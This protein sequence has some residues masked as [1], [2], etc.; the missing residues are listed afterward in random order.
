MFRFASPYYFFLLIPVGIAAWFVFRR[1]IRSGILFAPTLRIPE[2]RGS[3]RIIA[4]SLLPVL[5]IT[6]LVLTV[7][8]LARPQTV[9]SRIHNTSNA[10]GIEMVVDVSETMEALD[11]SIKTATGIKFRSRLEAAKETFGQFVNKRTDDLIGLV[12]FGGFAAT[13]VPLTA[14]HEALLHI[15]QG[16]EIPKPTFDGQGQVVDQEELL[17]AI[18]DALAT[19]CARLEHAKLKSKI[20]VLL[21]DGRSNTGIIKPEDATKIAKKMGI[22][23]YTIG[24]GSPNPAPFMRKDM[25]GNNTIVYGNVELD[26]ELLGNTAKITGGRYF[27]VRDP[28]GLDRAMEEINKL[29]KTKVERNIFEQYNELFP[30]FLWPALCLIAAGTGLNMM[31]SRRIL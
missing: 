9:Y 15:L 24:V 12:T 30:W 13:R 11:L 7:L 2:T 5:F 20:I 4:A 6:G 27:N 19:A 26:E 25:L 10:I 29:E 16:V 3:L 18:G 21:S 14:D 1:R 17:T 31:I 22:R 28:G 8:A 23:V